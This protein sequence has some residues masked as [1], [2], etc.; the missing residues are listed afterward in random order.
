MGIVIVGLGPGDPK[1]LTCEAWE[2]LSGA[3]EIYLRTGRHPVV[4]GLPPSVQVKTFDLLYEKADSF[5]EVYASIVQNVLELGGREQGVIYAV[6]GHPLVGESTVTALLDKAPKQGLQVQVIAGLSFIEPIMTALKLDAMDGLQVVDALDVSSKDYPPIDP[7]KPALLGQV[8]NRELASDVKLTLMNQ[9]PDEHTVFL[10]H[11]AGTAEE[12][13]EGCPL[14][15][16]D[17]SPDIA[18]LTSLYVPPLPEPSSLASFLETIARLRAPG[19]CPWD[20][21]QTHTSL[22]EGLIEETAEVL[23][24]LDADDMDSLKEELGDLLLHIFMHAQIASEEGDFNAAEVIHDIDSKIRRRHPHVFGNI[25]VSGVEQVLV[26]WDEIKQK[27]KGGKKKNTLDSVAN[28]LSALAQSQQLSRKASAVGLD[29]PDIGTLTG[30]IDERIREL[31]IAGT[32]DDRQAQIGK[33]LFEIANWARWL[34]V[35]PEISLRMANRHFR[36]RF[37][38]MEGGV[39]VQG[40]KVKELTRKEILSLWQAQ[41]EH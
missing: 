34:G 16:M 18:H 41:D 8:Y 1:N 10:V 32:A 33:L 17:H 13:V 35:D 19:G 37:D 9:Y 6:P 2:I 7:D 22:R 30:S 11:K 24:A 36:Q 4:S 12:V 25:E 14:Y 27:E 5:D 40:K 15:A 3:Q 38:A 20:Q 31:K 39:Q 23:D 29:W 21:E 26:N 28:S